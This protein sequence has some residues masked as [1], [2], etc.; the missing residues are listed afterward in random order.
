VGTG[1]KDTTQTGRSP[2]P[3]WRTV[4]LCIRSLRSRESKNAGQISWAAGV[5][6]PA[7]LGWAG[8]MASTD[9]VFEAAAASWTAARL[10][11]WYGSLLSVDP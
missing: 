3:R 10:R 7:E 9:E 2:S 11:Q 6:V 8:E 1:A 5:A 4:R